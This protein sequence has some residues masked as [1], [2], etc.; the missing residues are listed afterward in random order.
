M[1]LGKEKTMKTAGVLIAAAV[2]VGLMISGVGVHAIGT[3]DGSGDGLQGDV[4]IGALAGGF[5][6]PAYDSGWVSVDYLGKMELAHN[7]G[8]NPENYFVDLQFYAKSLEIKMGIHNLGIGG[9]LSGGTT[10][11]KSHGRGCYYREL[12]EDS[13]TVVNC[14]WPSGVSTRVR[15]RIWVYDSADGGGGTVLCHADFAQYEPAGAYV[16]PST[17]R[18]GQTLS[19]RFGGANTGTD[20]IAPGWRI[21]YYASTDTTITAADH[22]LYEATVDFGIAP[23]QRMAFDEAFT[24]PNTVPSGMYYVGWIFDPDNEICESNE[25]NNTG[26]ITSTRIGVGLK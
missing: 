5:P 9:D 19:M 20:A 17:I 14:D 6:R 1:F 25:N 26:C 3:P 21:R 22:F 18:A 10:L 11:G 24:F 12:D 23:G 8:G 2:A 15:V 13:I 16:S 7:L 4:R